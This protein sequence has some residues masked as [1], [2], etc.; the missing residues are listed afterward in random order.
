MRLYKE[1]IG[2]F[3]LYNLV[4]LTII[5]QINASAYPKCL[6]DLIN[7]KTGLLICTIPDI[8]TSLFKTYGKIM[9]QAI[10]AKK[11]KFES[12][13][14]NHN[15]QLASIFHS[16]HE[17]STMEKA[18]DASATPAQLINISMIEITNAKNFPYDIRGWNEKTFL[19]KTWKAFKLH[20]SQYQKSIK[21]THPQ[22][23]LSNIR[24]HQSSNT[25]RLAD[26]LYARI[27]AQQ[28]EE[29]SR[30]EAITAERL[31]DQKMQDTMQQM[32]RSTQHMTTMLEQIHALTSTI[33]IL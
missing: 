31:A 29:E 9:E 18:S 4:E 11:S 1:T 25:T 22:Q 13:P 7:D 21:K 33:K 3:N 6:A 2:T 24:L 26:E 12:I 28:A 5:Q 19:L 32:V 10:S 8:L 15:K 16:I 23:S 20:F 17:Y 30:V 14:Y 27:T